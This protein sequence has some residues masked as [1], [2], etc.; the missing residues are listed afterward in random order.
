MK[1]AFLN[2]VAFNWHP[3][4]VLSHMLD[5][6]LFG[7]QPWGHH[8]TSML[9]HAVNTALVFLLLHRLTRARWRSL[10]VAALFGL[11]PLHVESVAWVAERKDVL[12]ACFGLLALVFYAR[13][14]LGRPGVGQPPSP[15][16]APKAQAANPRRAAFDYGPALLFFALGLMSKPMLVTWPFVMLLLDYWPLERFKPGCAWRLVREKIPF[17]LATAASVVTF[18][19]QKRTGAMAAG[20]NL[21]LG[22]RGGNALV[23]YCRYLGKLFWPTDLAVLY[24]H[25]GHWPMD[26]VLLAGAFLAAVSALLFVARRRRLFASD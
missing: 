16:A 26:R 14:A 22:V 8:L 2:P 12:S 1:W 4:T 5:C 23:S 20:E 15:S 24:P 25:P 13:Y 3:L 6:Q 19:V 11:H 18:L 9:L 21:A 17:A 7:L 10:L